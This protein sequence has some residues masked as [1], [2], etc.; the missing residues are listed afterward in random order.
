MDLICSLA[1]GHQAYKHAD[2]P[3]KLTTLAKTITKVR[4]QVVTEQARAV[5]TPRL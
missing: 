3:K 2:M 1:N 5:I 4:Y